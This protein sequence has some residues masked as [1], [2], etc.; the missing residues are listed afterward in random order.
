MRTMVIVVSN[1]GSVIRRKSVKKLLQTMIDMIGGRVRQASAKV[2]ILHRLKNWINTQQG[3]E[4]T[5]VV[6]SDLKVI[7]SLRARSLSKNDF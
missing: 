5:G 7:H 3:G 1:S 6:Y 2:G 4:I